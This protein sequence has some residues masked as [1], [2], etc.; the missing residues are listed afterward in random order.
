ML[1][2]RRNSLCPPDNKVT[3]TLRYRACSP[4]DVSRDV[5]P[6]QLVYTVPGRRGYV[7]SPGFDWIGNYPPNILCRWNITV[8]AG[9]VIRLDFVFFRIPSELDDPDE[10]RI[11]ITSQDPSLTNVS[12]LDVP[13]LTYRNRELQNVPGYAIVLPGNTAII[14]FYSDDENSNKGFHI[15]FDAADPSLY[16]PIVD[17]L[18]LNCSG[19]IASSLP[20][21][22]RC[23]F[24]PDCLDGEDEA[25]CSYNST[26]CPHGGYLIGSKCV[27]IHVPDSPISW[28]QA[29]QECRDR[30]GGHLYTPRDISET[31]YLKKLNAKNYRVFLLTWFF[32]LRSYNGRGANSEFATGSRYGSQA[33][34]RTG[35]A[36][37][38]F[39]RH[40]CV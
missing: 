31:T 9:H 28:E 30:Y 32:G 38:W 22:V 20:E 21:H 39:Y 24:R 7:K 6:Q 17:T 33:R 40:D 4:L 19:I 25:D 37:S 5:C 8:E 11:Y 12:N 2:L 36:S 34:Y 14:E 18:T 3:F 15:K 35:V 16:V 29:E 27:Y 23:D 26:H 13:I 1:A 10:V